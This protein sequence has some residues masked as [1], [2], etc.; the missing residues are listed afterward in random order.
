M[1]TYE[2]SIKLRNQ[3]N[4]KN[5][6]Q[7]VQP[8]L[9]QHHLNNCTPIVKIESQRITSIDENVPDDRPYE[10]FHQ[11]NKT[12]TLIN[13]SEVNYMELNSKQLAKLQ[14]LKSVSKKKL[15]EEADEF[16]DKMNTSELSTNK[17]QYL[18]DSSLDLN[19]SRIPCLKLSDPKKK[20][21]KFENEK[22]KSDS[23]FM[24]E[25]VNSTSSQKQVPI[26][27]PITSNI[28]DNNNSNDDENFETYV[29]RST[30]RS[31]LVKLPN[32]YNDTSPE[33][34]GSLIRLILS[35]VSCKY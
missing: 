13:S 35:F 31:R 18:G 6:S 30:R 34:T 10:S 1:S 15:T 11:L 14:Q 24:S 26:F 4:T 25:S 29:K 27:L 16:E 2:H 21:S 20:Y 5:A 12:S 8:K 9:Q 23:T 22:P 17:D 19:S 3:E 7:I 33:L 28:S 32:N